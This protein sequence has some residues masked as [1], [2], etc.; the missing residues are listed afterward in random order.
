MDVIDRKDHC[1][2]DIFDNNLVT[3]DLVE[4]IFNMKFYG[5]VVV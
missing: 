2:L 3:L 4:N 5:N 1:F